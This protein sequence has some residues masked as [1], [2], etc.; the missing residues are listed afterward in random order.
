MKSLTEEHLGKDKWC[1]IR[2][3][4]GSF[5]GTRPN[6][7]QRNLEKGG[8][9]NGPTILPASHSLRNLALIISGCSK[10]LL[11]LGE[12]DAERSPT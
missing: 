5:L 10:A 7:E 3:S 6:G 8:V 11:R 9:E 2:N 4:D 12:A 1:I